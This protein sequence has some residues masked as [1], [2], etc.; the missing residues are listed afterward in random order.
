M[1]YNKSSKFIG[2]TGRGHVHGTIKS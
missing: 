2:K 1:T